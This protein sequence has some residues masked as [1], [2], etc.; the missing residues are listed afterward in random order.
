M[1]ENKICRLCLGENSEPP[2]MTD[3]IKFLVRKYFHIQITCED[4][5][6]QKIC[7][8]CSQTLL[9]FNSFETSVFLKQETLSKFLPKPS[10]ELK[11]IR[12]P[13]NLESLVR[14]LEIDTELVEFDTNPFVTEE[15]SPKIVTETD[16]DDAEIVTVYPKYCCRTCG[17]QFLN[18]DDFE[19][20]LYYHMSPPR[21]ETDDEFVCEICFKAFSSYFSLETHVKG[22]EFDPKTCKICEKSFDNQLK[23]D[24][25]LRN[26][27]NPLI[28]LRCDAC[29]RLCKN[30]KALNLHRY[31][32][33]DPKRHQETVKCDICNVTLSY[34]RGLEHHNRTCHP[35]LG[36]K[37]M[38]KY[39]CG[40]CDEKF[41]A[42]DEFWTHR[43][44]NHA[45][46]DG[47]S[48]KI[49]KLNSIS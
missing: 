37:S 8:N 29:G 43:I 16:E 42:I 31:L 45:K 38:G 18:Q 35:E 5:T 23:L 2:E 14:E 21:H 11:G 15:I 7:R 24:G 13:E 36:K 47:S 12:I 30:E 40:S 6:P 9:D 27:H 39:K 20:H 44:R 28:F 49:R 41:K 32:M 48:R 22:H 4:K 10:N 3:K 34:H 19:V 25:H 33:H 26:C 17:R 1:T 46:N